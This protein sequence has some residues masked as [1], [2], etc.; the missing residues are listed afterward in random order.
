MEEKAD[1]SDEVAAAQWYALRVRSRHEFIVMNELQ[2]KGIFG[3]LPYI[4]KW[5]RWKD[6]MKLVEFPLFPGYLF[7]QIQPH[8][9]SYVSALKTRGAVSFV[10]HDG[11]PV[12]IPAEEVAALRLMVESEQELNVYPHLT[13]GVRVKIVRGPLCGAEGVLQKRE[14]HF[15]FLVNI[16]LLSK[17][18]GVSVC[19]ED[20]KPL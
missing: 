11:R 3:Y 19:A 20:I 10:A 5:R 7:V 6:R 2:Q 18:V 1:A 12:P 17:S 16:V 13:E 4:K 9:A 8:A 14:R 15:M